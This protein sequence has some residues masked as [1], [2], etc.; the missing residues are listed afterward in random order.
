MPIVH[1]AT[2][3]PRPERRKKRRKPWVLLYLLI[4]LAIINYMR[5]V[6]ATVTTL[7]LPPTPAIRQPDLAWPG[8]GQAA[9]GAAGY[10]V[11]ATSGNQDEL[12]TASTAK[13]ITALCVLQKQPLEAGQ[14]GPTYTIGPADVSI[15]NGYV[16]QNG[17][18][19]PV[20]Q[21]EQLTEYQA[22]EALMVPSANNIADSLV[23]W[24]FGSQ[25]A[26][27]D[28]ARHFLQQHNLTHTHIGIDASGFDPST[29]SN[30]ADLTQLGLLAL[31]SPALMRIA[32][33]KQVDLPVVGT[34][35]NYNTVLGENGIT[36]LKTGNNDTDTG[37]FVFTASYRLGDKD[38]SL[39]GAV[40]GAADLDS[41]LHA[42]SNL[43]AS[44]EQG[45]TQ[46]TIAKAGQ[47]VGSVRAPWGAHAPVVAT[48]SLQIIRWQSTPV[49]T[50]SHL[51]NNT[52]NGIV[53]SIKATSGQAAA[54]TTLQLGH[55]LSGPG[56]W[57][58]LT[59]F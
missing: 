55:Q 3:A 5:P 46:T 23:G 31:Q 52:G 37:A 27:A 10:G 6:P 29:T 32:N 14:S 57:W 7:R 21:G 36:G 42:A 13:I 26:Y 47:S 41:A 28:Y 35:S 39:T 54:E 33:Q 17:S 12:A 30:A 1:P 51:Q 2:Y 50:T 16:Q 59:R 18:V 20:Q 8:T 4:L 48:H 9:V 15:Y 38:L 11:L 49:I 25:T 24:V 22:L 56:F 53:G 44:V 40:M 45:F 43:A 58:R 34:V 19:V